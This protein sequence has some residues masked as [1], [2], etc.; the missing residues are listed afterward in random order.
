MTP[1]PRITINARKF[2]GSIHRSWKAD[3]IDERPDVMIF[4]GVFERDIEHAELGLIAGGTVSYEYY[5]RDEWFNVFRFHEPDGS[6]RNWYCNVNMPP[7]FNGDALDYIDLDLDLL[8]WDDFRVLEL[9]REDFNAN[10]ALFGYSSEV[11]AKS[12][13]ALVELKRMIAAREFPFTAET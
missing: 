9:D 6:I 1:D 8:V 3:L 11:I 4:R 13:E 2:D 7:T 5:W 10:A 12:E